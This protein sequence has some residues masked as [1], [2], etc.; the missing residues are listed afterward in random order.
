MDEAEFERRLR[1]LVADAREANAP[2]PGAYSVRSPHPDV[3]D[4]DVDVTQVTNR[5]PAGFTGE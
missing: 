2:I 3:Q 4:Y 1:Q 5:P